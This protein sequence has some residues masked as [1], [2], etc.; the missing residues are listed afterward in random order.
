MGEGNSIEI[1]AGRWDSKTAPA[2]RCA[3]TVLHSVDQTQIGAE[4][5]RF[6]HQNGVVRRLQAC[7]HEL[8]I[9]L[10]GSQ[11]VVNYECWLFVSFNVNIICLSLAR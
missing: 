10:Q 1:G 6:P 9:F 7:Y 3:I 11:R 8:S 2:S 5:D 4:Y